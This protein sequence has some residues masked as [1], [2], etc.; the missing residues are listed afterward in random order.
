MLGRI[1][2][3][4][5]VFNFYGNQ[6]FVN[7]E[8]SLNVIDLEKNIIIDTVRHDSLGYYSSFL[9]SHRKTCLL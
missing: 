7:Q 4:I 9:Q 5:E 3:T 6:Q 2:N 1:L 8:R